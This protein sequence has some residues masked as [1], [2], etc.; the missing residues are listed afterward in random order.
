MLNCIDLLTDD[1]DDIVIKGDLQLSYDSFKNVAKTAERRVSARVDDFLL[2]NV[3]AGIEEKLL[4]RINE[5]NKFII[6]NKISRVLGINNLLFSSEY[7]I[8]ILPENDEGKLPILLAFTSPLV[9][10]SY[11]FSVIINKQNQRSY[12]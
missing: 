8:K 9:N 5:T 3:G 6:K 1:S 11:N 4:H 10:K 7:D 12:S 2:E